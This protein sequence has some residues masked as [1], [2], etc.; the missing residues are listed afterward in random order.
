MAWFSRFNRFGDM[1]WVFGQENTIACGV[2]CTIM[3]VFKIHKI[4]PGTKAVYTEEQ[5]IK[6][7][8][9]MFGPNPLGAAGLNNDQLKQLLNAPELKMP[10]WDIHTIDP[11]AVPQTIIDKVGVTKRMGP[12]VNVTPMILGIDW[13]GGGGHWVLVDT[14]REFMGKRYATVCDPWDANVHM[15]PISK[16]NTFEYTGK[17]VV[18][19]DFWGKRHNYDSPSTGGVFL[20]DV[21]YR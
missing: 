10:G 8:E 12:V 21:V 3:A 20:G 7:A 4:R 2:A 19:F 14:V 13:S 5:I 6:L 9:K 1:H 17:N 15:V 11:K 16:D 18:G